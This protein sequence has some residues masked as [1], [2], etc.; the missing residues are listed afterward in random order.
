MT[1]EKYPEGLEAFVVR[2]LEAAGIPRYSTGNLCLI[3]MY[4]SS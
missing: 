3:S 4:G 2:Y 1:G